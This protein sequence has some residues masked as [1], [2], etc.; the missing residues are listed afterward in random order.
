[1]VL[2]SVGEHDAKEVLAALLD[3]LEVGKDKIDAWIGGS[4]KVMPRS[5]MSHLPWQP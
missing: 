3:E 1:M 4:A 5:T 2:M